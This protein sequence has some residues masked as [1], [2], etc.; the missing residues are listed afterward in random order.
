MINA[1]RV[2]LVSVSLLEIFI[3]GGMQF[4]WFA[5]VFILKQEGVL[6]NLC[7]TQQFD[8]STEEISHIEDCFPQDEQFNLIFSIGIAIFTVLSVVNGQL[9]QSFDIKRIRMIYISIGVAG[10]L[11]LAFTSTVSP[12]FALPGIVLVGTGG[13]SLLLSDYIQIPVSLQRGSSIYIG[14]MNGCYDS[15]VLTFML[16][17]VCPKN[18][19]VR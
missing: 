4:G 17:K 15:S 9:Y 16:V 5:L 14:L 7:V 19:S 18:H 2:A 10:L 8:N 12:W 1:R 3:F 13:Q 11:F 6:K